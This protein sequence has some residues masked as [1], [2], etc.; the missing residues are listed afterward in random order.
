MQ[1]FNDDTITIL[2]C[3]PITNHCWYNFQGNYYK[4]QQTYHTQWLIINW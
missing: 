1:E 2:H 3:Q 4:N